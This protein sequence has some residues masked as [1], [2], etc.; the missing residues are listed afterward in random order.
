MISVS[1]PPHFQLP[2]VRSEPRPPVA[3][4]P[5]HAPHILG[6]LLRPASMVSLSRSRVGNNLRGR[7]N[8]GER[9]RNENG[10]ET[11]GALKRLVHGWCRSRVEFRPLY[12]NLDGHPTRRECPE[13]VHKDSDERLKPRPAATVSTRYNRGADVNPRAQ[14]LRPRSPPAIDVPPVAHFD[15]VDSGDKKRK[16][17]PAP[18]YGTADDLIE[19]LYLP[20]PSQVLNHIFEGQI[21]LTCPLPEGGEIV[22]VFRQ[23]H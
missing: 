22:G 6:K 20:T 12:Q 21:R 11:E 9:E 15:N 3:F 18:I 17:A 8:G 2:V 7:E 1:E 19:T 10:E 23:P 13:S 14:G 5:W 16:P 4:S